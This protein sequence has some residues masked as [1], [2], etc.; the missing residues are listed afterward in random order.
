[1]EI[2][3]FAAI[4]GMAFVFDAPTETGFYMKDVLV[5]LDIAFIGADGKVIDVFTMPRCDAEPCPIYHAP[6]AFQWA[7]ETPEGGLTGIEPGDAFSLEPWA[8]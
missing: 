8:S 4:D 7:L 6:A 5:R 2:D 1:M 3:S